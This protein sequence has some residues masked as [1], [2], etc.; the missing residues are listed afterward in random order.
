MV[1]ATRPRTAW[2][3]R[4]TTESIFN[5]GRTSVEFATFFSS[6]NIKP[7]VCL[8]NPALVDTAKCKLPLDVC[9]DNPSLLPLLGCSG[10]IHLLYL[11]PLIIL[12]ELDSAQSRV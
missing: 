8:A 4:W 7:Q 9:L 12:S 6:N 11:G 1:L 3:L 10:R 5:I 2:L